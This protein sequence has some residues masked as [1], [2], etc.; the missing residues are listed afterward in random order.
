MKLFQQMLVA[1]AAAGLLAPVATQASDVINLDGMNDYSRSKKTSNRIDSKTFINNVDEDIAVL[2]GRVD[3]LEAQQNNFEAGA[4]SSTTTM[5][6][7]A[8]MW[9]GAV[10]GANEI[11]GTDTES[12]Q[13]GYTYTMNLNTTFTGDDNLY[14]RLK[15]G[16]SGDVWELKP[17]AYHIETKNTSDNFNVDKMWY[18]FPV[19]DNITAFVGP[20]IENYYMYI[21]PSIYKPGALKAFKLGGNSNFGASTDT[22]FGF[23]Y[24]TDG[25]FGV[26]T[27]IVSKGSDGYSKAPLAKGLMGKNDVSK[28]DTQVAYTTDRWHVSATLSDAQNWTSQQYNA[29][30]FGEDT[31]TDST[32]YALR[33]YWRPEASGT[34]VPEISVGYDTKSFEGGAT[35]AAKE[36][37]SYMVGLNW[38]DMFQADDTIGLAFTQPLKVTSVVGGGTV[39]EVDPL[40]WELYYS[41][42][43]ND[44]MSITPA[45]FGGTDSWADAE[46]DTFGAVVTTTFKF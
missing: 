28:W 44:S 27:N 26:A 18:T 36:A 7:K 37:D 35:G 38:K 14:V 15:A 21:T 41:F 11:D 10:D 1:T 22:G 43:P 33:A 2:N 9:I 16:E 6:G 24:E 8:I 20:R 30:A 42:K 40:L 13:T 31:A 25:G 23:K 45:V 29:T 17:A 12:V 4:F 46:D 5:D 34:A 19:G 3:G 32:G 39:T